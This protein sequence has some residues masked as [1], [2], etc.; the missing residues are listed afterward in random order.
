MKRSLT[1]RKELPE[2]KEERIPG[3]KVNIKPSIKKYGSQKAKKPKYR[4]PGRSEDRK[5]VG[6]VA[7]KIKR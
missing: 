5:P 6:K 4:K 3:S 2:S 1:D 7:K